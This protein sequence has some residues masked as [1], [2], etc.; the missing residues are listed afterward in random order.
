VNAIRSPFMNGAEMRCGKKVLPVTAAAFA[1]GIEA[2][3]C[4][5][6]SLAIG[7]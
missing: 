2:R 3:V 6:M 5:G 1:G 7:L 4:A